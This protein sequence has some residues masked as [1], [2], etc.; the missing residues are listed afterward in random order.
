MRRG[1]GALRARGVPMM[2]DKITIIII[3]MCR[4]VDIPKCVASAHGGRA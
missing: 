2:H 3:I 4:Y 1:Q